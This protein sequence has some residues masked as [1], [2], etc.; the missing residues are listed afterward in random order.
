MSDEPSRCLFIIGQALGAMGMARTQALVLLNRRKQTHGALHSLLPRFCTETVQG[1]PVAQ[2]K[3]TP[4]LF[5]LAHI[6]LRMGTGGL[7]GWTS[8]PFPQRSGTVQG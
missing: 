4:A 6:N 1:L 5:G 8:K 3:F 7:V 2:V